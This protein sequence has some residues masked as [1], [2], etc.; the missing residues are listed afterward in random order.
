LVFILGLGFYIVPV[1]LGGQRDV[2]IAQL[3][4]EQVASFGDWGVAGALAVILLVAT[5]I[6]LGVAYKLFGVRNIW[7]EI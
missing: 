2:M 5:G 3:I 6:I 4:Y 1:L 7:A